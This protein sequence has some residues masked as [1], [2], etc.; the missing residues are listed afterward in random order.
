MGLGWS[1][2]IIMQQ[3]MQPTRTYHIHCT[4][5]LIYHC[6]SSGHPPSLVLVGFN[7]GKNFLCSSQFR[8][9][10]LLT[11]SLLLLP[12][13]FSWTEMKVPRIN[14]SE[15]LRI[16]FRINIS[17]YGEKNRV[18]KV[19]ETIIG[20]MCVLVSNAGVLRY[21]CAS[22][23]N[24]WIPSHRYRLYFCFGFELNSLVGFKSRT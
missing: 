22:G 6:A 19:V 21:C 11:R 13:D 3:S 15:K 2:A 9:S 18:N 12:W 23:T 20:V 1:C 24:T 8:L 14:L 7:I 10:E 5:P 17:N 4:T 16:R